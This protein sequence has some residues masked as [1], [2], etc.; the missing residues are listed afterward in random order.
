MLKHEA[1]SSMLLMLLPTPRVDKNDII[2]HNDEVN[3]IS[4]ENTLL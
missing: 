1:Q 3:Y 2:E 4:Y